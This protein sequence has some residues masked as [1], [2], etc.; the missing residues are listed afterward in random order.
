MK[1]LHWLLQALPDILALDGALQFV[2]LI[3]HF[4]DLEAGQVDGLGVVMQLSLLLGCQSSH[5]LHVCEPVVSRFLQ[6]DLSL[7]V[8]LSMQLD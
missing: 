4:F 7:G 2:L 1:L 8:Q 5:R 6:K 3:H